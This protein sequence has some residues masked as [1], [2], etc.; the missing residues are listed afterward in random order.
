MPVRLEQIYYDRESDYQ[1]N[2]ALDFVKVTEM[3]QW[4]EFY[5]PSP[6]KA[7]WHWQTVV[8]SSTGYEVF[9]NFWPHTGKCQMDGEG[10]RVGLKNALLLITRAMDMTDDGE[11]IDNERG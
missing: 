5:Q 3:R 10:S 7:P 6:S 2:N 1:R 4:L 8:T 11:V 9:L